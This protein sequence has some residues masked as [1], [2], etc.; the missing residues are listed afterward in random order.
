[1]DTRLSKHDS[2]CCAATDNSRRMHNVVGC[3]R[4]HLKQHYNRARVLEKC[5]SDSYACL[6]GVLPVR[7]VRYAAREQHRFDRKTLDTF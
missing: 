3:A 1:M 4:E 6:S 7:G 2:E 5:D